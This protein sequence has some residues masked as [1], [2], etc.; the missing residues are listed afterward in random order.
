MFINQ[1]EEELA[2][3][4]GDTSSGSCITAGHKGWQAASAHT[5]ACVWYTIQQRNLDLPQKIAIKSHREISAEFGG[6]MSRKEYFS[7]PLS[8]LWL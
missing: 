1:P 7:D 8:P 6:M 5:C 4:A 3:A 2:R